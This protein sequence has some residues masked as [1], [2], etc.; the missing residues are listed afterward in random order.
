MLEFP[1]KLYWVWIL[2]WATRMDVCFAKSR[3]WAIFKNKAWILQIV[4]T[5]T[6]ILLMIL[7]FT[8]GELKLIVLY[9]L[10]KYIC[11]INIAIFSID[12]HK[13][14]SRDIFSSFTH[15]WANNLI[16]KSPTNSLF[17]T[18]Y[19]QYIYF[20]RVHLFSGPCFS[21]TFFFVP[22]KI[23]DTQN[24]CITYQ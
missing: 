2:T 16:L 22:F 24:T 23:L 8:E 6:I 12:L 13:L 15:F 10:S 9:I 14:F 21:K 19:F 11:L 17:F 4:T 20:Q 7:H 3:T 1:S 18:L 5:S